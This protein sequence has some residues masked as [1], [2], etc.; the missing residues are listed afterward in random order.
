MCAAA[1][2]YPRGQGP[3]ARVV[4][5]GHHPPAGR[6]TAGTNG[7]CVGAVVDGEC[8]GQPVLVFLARLGFPYVRP[9]PRPL[10]GG[11]SAAYVRMA[12]IGLAEPGA[13]EQPKMIDAKWTFVDSNS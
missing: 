5:R 8:Q 13:F 1:Q 11:G 4:T 10:G 9:G 2:F 6:T 3:Q 7:L 12:V